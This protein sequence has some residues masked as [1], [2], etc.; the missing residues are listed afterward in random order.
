[1]NKRLGTVGLKF[2]EIA[3]T[4]ADRNLTIEDLMAQPE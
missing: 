4:A 3:G 2:G 1:L